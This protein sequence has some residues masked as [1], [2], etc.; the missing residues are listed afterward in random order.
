[1]RRLSPLEAAWQAW[2][3]DGELNGHSPAQVIGFASEM[4][5]LEGA[6]RVRF[7]R[8]LGDIT[9]GDVEP[10]LLAWWRRR[11]RS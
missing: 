2:R 9:L 3:V 4:A 8:R 6:E 10:R 11:R 1:M 7:A 5:D